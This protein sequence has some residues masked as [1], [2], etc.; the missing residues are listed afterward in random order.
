MRLEWARPGVVRATAHA[1][2][3]AAMVAA[4]RLVA[5]SA[6]PEIPPEALEQLRQ[7]LDEYDAQAERLREAPSPVDGG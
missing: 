3:F 7:V 6:S 2:E 1:Y 5:E 4:A